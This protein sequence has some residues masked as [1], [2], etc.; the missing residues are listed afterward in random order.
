MCNGWNHDDNCDCGFGPP[1]RWK[2]KA[3]PPKSWYELSLQDRLTYKH[4]LMGLGL[5]RI[6]IDEELHRYQKHDFPLSKNTW[7]S[8]S[9]EEKVDWKTRFLTFFGLYR[10]EERQHIYKDIIIPIFKL[11]SP[12]LRNSKVTYEEA[13]E[14]QKAESWS[15]TILGFGTG[16]SQVFRLVSTSEFSSK[17]GACKLVYLPVTLQLTSLKFYRGNKFLR[18]VLRVEPSPKHENEN[19]NCGVK[20]Q[21]K[22]ACRPDRCSIIGSSEVYPLAEELPSSICTYSTQWSSKTEQRFSTGVEAFKLKGLCQATVRREATITL[23]FDLPGGHDY[24]MFQ[25]K[26]PDGLVWEVVRKLRK[27]K[28]SNLPHTQYPQ[29]TR[30]CDAER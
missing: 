21:Q 13:K 15:V 6:E 4:H 28:C 14:F 11:H 10:C 25:L 7:K 20:R 3:G 26:E 18:S 1:Y 23:T 5:S 9:V 27:G 12:N 30:H 22:A 19:M 2:I 8:L 17:A 24:R 29:T 16:N